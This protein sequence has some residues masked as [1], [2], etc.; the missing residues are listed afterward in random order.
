MRYIILGYGKFGKLALERLSG[1]SEPSEILVVDRDPEVLPR[2]TGG[3]A[4]WVVSDAVSFLANSARVRPEDV[5]VP[6][7][8]FNLAAAYVLARSSDACLIP[9]PA[10]II[11]LLPNRFQVNASNLCCSRA[12][13][14]CPDDC[15]EGEL[16]TVTGERR[17]P[18]FAY[19]QELTVPGC[20][21]L[22]LRS[23][24]ITPGIGGYT[25]GSLREM[26]RRLTRGRYLIA[27]S[28]KCHAIVTALVKGTCQ[29]E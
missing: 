23:F 9:I 6:M 29:E 18:L 5:I 10:E 12:D 1:L 13:F 27:T 22:V 19:I 2:D 7:V 3:N 25:F 28:C 20:E 14:I 11:G 8:P 21:V 24:Q 15:P 16:C 26:E 4:Q 17:E